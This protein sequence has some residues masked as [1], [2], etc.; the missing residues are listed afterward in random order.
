M[1]MA[2]GSQRAVAPRWESVAGPVLPYARQTVTAAD[3]EA[4][5]AVLRGDWLT[6]GPTVRRFEEAV[7][8]RCGARYAVAVA[9]G[10]AGLHLGALA[11]G[12]GPGDRLWTSPNSFVASANCGLYCGA[13]IGF[14]DID[15]GTLNLSAARLREQLAA[16]RG[17][18]VLPK[19]IVPVHF[20]GQSCRMDEIAAAAREHGVAVMEDAAH[21]TGATFLGEPVGCCRY[22]DLAVFSFHPV[23]IITTGEGGMVLTNRED[24]YRRLLELRS[25]GITRDP[26]RMSGSPDG[27][28]YYQQVAL[29]LHYRLTD[30]QCALGLSQLGR[31]DAF[32][33]RRRALA[34]R[35]DHL[36]AGLPVAIPRRDPDAESSWHLYAVRIPAGGPVGRD[37]VFGR[38]R[39]AGVE[40]N[41][42]Y[43]PIY[44]QP[45]YAARGFAP[46]LC[47]AAEAYY[48]EALS[49]PM[50]AGLTDGDQGR[51][52]EI[53][54]AAL[55]PR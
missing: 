1:T 6:Q 37:A 18:G 30:F 45:V 15:P 2:A 43:I 26:G 25:H 20:G 42:H 10:T 24:L 8:A 46:G 16:A 23:K 11:L 19:V 35:Y 52:A 49:L 51:V 21:A 41:V 17:A 32:L 28:W 29:G 50:F 14:V 12:L 4:V 55:A 39:A 13:D 5:V 54:A 9:S 47:P 48:R 27:P 44:R 22:A 33:A 34:D 36:L 7:A 38:M 40:V 53:L 3:E 31:L